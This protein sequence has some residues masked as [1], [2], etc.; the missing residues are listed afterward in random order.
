M[1]PAGQELKTTFS[2]TPKAILREMDEQKLSHSI[3]TVHSSTIIYNNC[4][5]N[6]TI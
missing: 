4:Q 1:Q 6:Y 5:Y 3:A 2:A